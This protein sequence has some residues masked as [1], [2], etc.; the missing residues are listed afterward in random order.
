MAFNQFPHIVT[1]RLEV[2][3]E[4]V[5]EFGVA[6]SAPIE[7]SPIPVAFTPTGGGTGVEVTG[8]AFF[9]RYTLIGNL[10]YFSYQVVFTNISN[11]GTGQ[12]F[13]NLPFPTLKPLLTRNGCLHDTSTGNQFHI[14]GHAFEGTSR[15]DLFSSDKVGSSVQDVQF[16]Q[17]SPI[18]LTTADTF[19]IEGFYEADLS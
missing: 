7:L 5:V 3:D 13:M 14:S 19:H 6:N 18:T 2:A 12:Y 17:G 11:F 10:C 9:G 1:N 8:D 4:G 15:M 16:E